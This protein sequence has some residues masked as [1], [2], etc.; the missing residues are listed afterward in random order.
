MFV[1]FAVSNC[2]DGSTANGCLVNLPETPAN[3][4]T[5]SSAMGLVF[6]IIA[7]V[8]VIIIIVQG[9]KFALSNGDAQKAADARRGILYAI[10]G[11]AV[12][13]SAEIIVQLV[14]GKL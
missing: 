9:I 8:T 1:Q 11:L 14:I 7:A 6:A 5:L 3:A 4:S 10:I 2:A 12:S 13:V